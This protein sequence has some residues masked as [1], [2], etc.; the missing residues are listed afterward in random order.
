MIFKTLVLIGLL[1]SNV[2][3]KLGAEKKQAPSEESFGSELE[4]DLELMIE[5]KRQ[6]FPLLPG[7]KCPTGHHCHVRTT[8]TGMAP[9]ISS[10]KANLKTPLAA[11]LDWQELDS[12]LKTVVASNDYCS[13]RSAMA[14]AA[15]LAAGVAVSTVSM[16]AY[17]AETKDVKMGSD[18]GQLVF[19]PAKV[20]ICKGDSVKWTNNKG[21]PH[22]VVFDEDNIPGGV[23]QEKISMDDQ[24]GEEGDTFTMKFDT[25]GEY[26]YYCEPH[27][28]AGM[29]ATL[30]V[31]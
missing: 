7:T 14:R 4:L 21:G 19:V 27:R 24:L 16:P 3:A 22:N 6:L 29:G 10:L 25:A 26:G 15:G 30:I 8:R 18:S 28:G 17:A 23:D 12:N 13:R 5:G 2:S 9:M 1:S 20:T 31:A 11:T